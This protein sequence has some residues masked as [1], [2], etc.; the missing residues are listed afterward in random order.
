MTAEVWGEVNR[1]D[2]MVRGCYRTPS[3]DKQADEVFYKQLAEASWFSALQLA[4]CLLEIQNSREE[5]S[6][7]GSWSVWKTTS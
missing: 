6:P 1:E 7:G 5:I 2:L 4:K 3:Q